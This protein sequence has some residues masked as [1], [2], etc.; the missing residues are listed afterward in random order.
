MRNPSENRYGNVGLLAIFVYRNF[1]LCLMFIA[2][3][4]FGG[5]MSVIGSAGSDMGI[6]VGI[7]LA[8]GTA[9]CVG[10]TIVAT[11]LFDR[12]RKTGSIS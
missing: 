5:M 1:E 4:V 6:A 3:S 8:S 7:W 9:V 2:G 11:H 10:L 12:D